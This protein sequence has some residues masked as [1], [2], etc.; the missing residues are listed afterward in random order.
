[1]KATHP[2]PEVQRSCSV[3]PDFDSDQPSPLTPPRSYSSEA[4]SPP[5]SPPTPNSL[6]L[7]HFGEGGELTADERNSKRLFVTLGGRTYEFE[8]SIC[9]DLSDGL[10][11]FADAK[12]FKDGQVSFRR[13]MKYPAIVHDE[14]LVVKWDGNYITRRDGSQ[15]LVALVTWR[16]AALA[17]PTNVSTLSEEEPLSSSD[18]RE[19]ED[20]T[21]KST[22]KKASSWVRWWRSSRSDTTKM[23]TTATANS[24]E[25]PSPSRPNL[26][27][28]ASAPADQVSSLDAFFA[29]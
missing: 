2:L 26:V 27:P 10:D 11:E 17:K 21:D 9:E 24:K 25:P 18:E 3:P 28:S 12:R 1:M 6:S 13:F 7:Q 16:D 4:P 19:S 23:P 5:A 22:P 8:L 20:T 14:N 29:Q 15:L